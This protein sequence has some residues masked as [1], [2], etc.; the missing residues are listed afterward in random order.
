MPDTVLGLME[1]IVN[2][3]NKVL[4]SQGLGPRVEAHLLRES[5][6]LM[7]DLSCEKH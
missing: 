7:W 5:Q 1:K 4:A 3:T 6:G 2:Q